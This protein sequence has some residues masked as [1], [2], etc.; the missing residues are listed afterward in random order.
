MRLLITC[1]G[2]YPVYCLSQDSSDWYTSP[3]LSKS[4]LRFSTSMLHLDKVNIE[5]GNPNAGKAKLTTM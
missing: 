3:R 1:P 2:V 5:R 4:V